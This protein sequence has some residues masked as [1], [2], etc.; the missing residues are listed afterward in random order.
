MSNKR[1]AA[2]LRNLCCLMILAFAAV[3]LAHPSFANITSVGSVDLSVT[4]TNTTATSINMNV[5]GTNGGIT[6]APNGTGV[7]TVGGTTPTVTSQG[8]LTLQSASGSTTSIG[9]ASGGS[10]TIIQAGSGGS[11]QLTGTNVGIG[12]TSPASTLDVN[13]GVR[14]ANDPAACSSA[15]AGTLKYT[16]GSPAYSYCN[17]STWI[18]LTTNTGCTMTENLATEV[19]TKGNN[20]PG[21][22][23]LWAGAS[24]VFGTGGGSV[25][26]FSYSGTGN[27]ATIAGTVALAGANQVTGDATYIYVTNG[28]TGVEAYTFNGTTFTLKATYTAG[29]TVTGIYSDG[30]Y[31][32]VS[33]ST[34]IV[35]LTFNGTTFTTKGTYA[36][37][38]LGSTDMV[39]GSSA[40]YLYFKAGTYIGALTFNG[41]TFTLKG[42]INVTGANIWSVGTDGTYIYATPQYDHT[43]VY[44]FN[45]TT[46]SLVTSD[47]VTS[48]AYEYVFSGGYIYMSTGFGIRIYTYN[49]SNFTVKAQY[50]NYINSTGLALL[51]SYVYQSD[52]SF[53][54]IVV[55]KCN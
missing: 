23:A 3:H 21:F 47:G 54:T 19:N 10:S 6:L 15:K 27:T 8:G 33:S 28:S 42:S 11:I 40:S 38:A 53:G 43:Y 45:G 2:R 44:T 41:T 30:T 50:I 24:Y 39:R 7:V 12:T 36:A 22:G 14:V 48:G 13:G 5:T 37:S 52:N 46:F 18:P 55:G 20:S 25:R 9:N 4:G 49:G 17:G 35:A 51:G 16:G 34:N 29:A 32:Y 1:L 31:L 26:A